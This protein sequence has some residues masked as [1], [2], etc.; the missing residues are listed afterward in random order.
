VLVPAC[1]L[2]QLSSAPETDVFGH[3][4]SQPLMF[5]ADSVVRSD[6]TCGPTGTQPEWQTVDPHDVL[7]R[8]ERLGTG[9]GRT[10]TITTTLHLFG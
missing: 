8:A 10:Y 7:L 4:L 3:Q 1:P 2:K 5:L 9:M 6:T